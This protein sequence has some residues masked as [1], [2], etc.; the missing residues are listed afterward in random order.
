M[1][2]NVYR[3]LCTKIIGEMENT[4]TGTISPEIWK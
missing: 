3:G 1:L 2:K 4:R